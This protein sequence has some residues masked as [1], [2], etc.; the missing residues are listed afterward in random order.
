LTS[1]RRHLF[2]WL[3]GTLSI[4]ALLVTFASYAITLEEMNEVFDEE[5]K[6]VALTALTHSQEVPGASEPAP[7]SSSGD[8]EG[9][10]FVTQVWT[11]SGEPLFSSRPEV[12][13]PFVSDEGIR[14]VVTREGPWRVYTDRSAAHFVQAG[15]PIEVRHRLAAEIALKTLIPTLTGVPVLAL[16][17]LYALRR[18]LRPLTHTAEDLGQRSAM[19]LDPIDAKRL[20]LE[21][22]P[23]VGSINTLMDKL[24]RALAS[25]RR[26]TADAAHELRTPLT[27][28]G[29][30]VQLLMSA[31]DEAARA[32]AGADIRTGLS[33]ANRLVEQLLQMS[34]L[35]PEAQF[36]PDTPV[37]LDELAKTVVTDF[38]A[39]A[40]MRRVDLGVVIDHA[41]N[42]DH[43]VL[44]DADDLRVLLNNVVDNALRH[45][46]EGGRV[47]VSVR[48]HGAAR[49]DVVV[50]VS[51]CGPGIAPED[52]ERVF[53]RFYR[54]IVARD[55]DAAMGGTGLGLA[56]VKAVADRHRARIE[57][58]EGLPGPDGNRGL[59]FRLIFGRG[60]GATLSAI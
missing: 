3:M 39:L 22:Q 59:T 12:G 8:L 53:D 34:R 60:R 10:A 25:Q 56:I 21:L 57:L 43:V 30:Q 48:S 7:E 1:I 13:I 55:T 51:D 46:P 38:S 41:A 44:G 17:L 15:Q 11:L 36:A 14:T 18:G 23:L 5:L 50:E 27:A 26:F 9:F 29:L 19:S 54:K 6:Q 4:G 28:L 16:L 42:A 20:P 24:S 40:D 49:D 31:E 37:Q 32:E 2:F 58:A 35:D 47:D 33:R 52:Q 45:T